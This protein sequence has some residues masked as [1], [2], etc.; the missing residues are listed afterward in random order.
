MTLDEFKPMVG[1]KLL[2]DCSPPP[3]ELKLVSDVARPR[4]QRL[5]LP[6]HLQPG[7][8]PAHRLARLC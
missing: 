5:R 7:R 1:Q 4:G 8:S 2:A 6:G 3:I